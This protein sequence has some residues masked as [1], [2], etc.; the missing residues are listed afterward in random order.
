MFDGSGISRYNSLTMKQLVW[1]LRFMKS[2]SSYSKIFFNSLAVSGESGTLN[3]FCDGTIA[4]GEIH[5]KSG[6]MSR[7]RSYAG[8]VK[9]RSGKNLIFAFTVNNYNCKS[10]DMKRLIEE[11]MV[12]LVQYK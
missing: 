6:T 5:A 10:T 9:T 8:Y 1:M 11:F 12:K 4:A 2:N 7:V 3:S